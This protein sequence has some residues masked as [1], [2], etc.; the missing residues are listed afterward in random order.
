MAGRLKLVDLTFPKSYLEMFK[1][2][3]FGVQGL[4]EYL[5]IEE[6]QSLIT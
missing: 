6:D 2:P 5:K 3:K 1:G 4:R